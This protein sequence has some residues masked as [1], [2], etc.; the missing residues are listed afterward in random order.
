MRAAVIV[1]LA[2][3]AIVAAQNDGLNNPEGFVIDQ[4][5]YR[6]SNPPNGGYEPIDREPAY[7]DFGNQNRPY[8]GKQYNSP[9]LRGGK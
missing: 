3:V 4:A 2:L 9:D 6:P 5:F 1:L 8:P 7:V